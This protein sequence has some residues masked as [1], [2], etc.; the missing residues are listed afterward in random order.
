[1]RI[2]ED[3]YLNSILPTFHKLGQIVFPDPY[4]I[5]NQECKQYISRFSL[6][7]N[8]HKVFGGDNEWLADMLFKFLTN[9]TT[10]KRVNLLEFMQKF[11]VLWPMKPVEEEEEEG[12]DN[13]EY[14]AA[15]SLLYK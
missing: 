5:K 9:G 3:F 13:N 15:L 12:D 11:E 4:S 7:N 8:F 6:K 2:I 1:M 14:S 10:F